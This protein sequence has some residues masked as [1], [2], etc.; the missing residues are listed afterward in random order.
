MICRN[1]Y[2]WWELC[3]LLEKRYRG[4]LDEKADIY[5][6]FAVDGAE[7]M[8]RLIEGLLAYSRITRRGGE[9]KRVDLNKVF[10]LAVS[11]LVS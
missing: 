9:F 11:N 4:R 8:Q 1:R 10:A 3:Q 7:R 6:H 5:I 2:G